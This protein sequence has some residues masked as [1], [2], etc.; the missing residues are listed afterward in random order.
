[1]MHVAYIG[2]GSNLGDT[3]RH[4]RLAM[5]VMEASDRIILADV[6]QFYQTEPLEYQ[7]Q[8]W[9]LNAVV[10]IKTD[11][12]PFRLLKQLKT[13]E[14]ELGRRDS[15]VRFGPRPIDLD[16]LLYD[17][18][19]LQSPS[20]IIPH[21]RMHKRRFVL[22]PFCDINA[23][24]IHPVL[25]VTVDELLHRLEKCDQAVLPADCPQI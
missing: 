15:A 24:V 23:K 16:L 1:M 18:Q 5:Q 2:L 25:K 6:S 9:F 7:A 22:M 12:T 4:I 10:R 11:L 14:K 21:P 20:L 17:Q 19:V 8:D 13:M 3:C